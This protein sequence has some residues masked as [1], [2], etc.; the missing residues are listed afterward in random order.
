MG[1]FALPSPQHILLLTSGKLLLLFSV[2]LQSAIS[3][4]LFFNSLYVHIKIL[5]YVFWAQLTVFKSLFIWLFQQGEE[6]VTPNIVQ[7]CKKGKKKFCKS[8]YYVTTEVFKSLHEDKV[9]VRSEEKGRMRGKN[10]RKLDPWDLRR[11]KRGG[12][13]V[14]VLCSVLCIN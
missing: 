8:L 3:I 10:R 14:F 9:N 7:V 13:V 2:I 4:Y 12:C 5:E 6:R 1:F 11:S